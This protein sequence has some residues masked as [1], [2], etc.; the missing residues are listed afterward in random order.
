MSGGDVEDDAPEPRDS[1]PTGGRLRLF[2]DRWEEAGASPWT[3]S[4]VR[5]GLRL[6]LLHPETFRPRRPFDSASV[7]GH[8]DAALVRGL[9]PDM[10]QAR[11]IERC[12]PPRP[13][14]FANYDLI[15]PRLK[16]DGSARP[17][18]NAKKV[19]EHLRPPH[20]RMESVSTALQ[21]LNRGDACV[22]IDVQAAFPHIH[23]P[24]STRQ[25]L[26]FVFDGDHYRFR[27]M[28]FGLSLAPLIFT[29]VISFV[30]KRLRRRGIAL[31]HYCDD[32]LVTAPSPEAVTR[33]ANLV[34]K[35]LRHFGFTINDEKS[36]LTPTTDIVFL[37]VRINTTD[38]TLAVPPARVRDLRRS[39]RRLLDAA[40]QPRPVTG[41]MVAS[42]LGKLAA[43]ARAM[44]RA[45]DSFWNL[46]AWRKRTVRL[47]GWDRGAF[48]GKAETRELR[49]FLTF[50][51]DWNGRSVLSLSPDFAVRF[52]CRKPPEMNIQTDAS[53]W[54]WGALLVGTDLVARGPWSEALRRQSHN[55]KELRAAILAAKGFIRHRLRE[56]RLSGGLPTATTPWVVHLQ[57]DNTTT[58]SYLNNTSTRVRHL[59]ADATA[60]RKWLETRNVILRATHLPG[61]LNGPADDLSRVVHDPH[62]WKLARE[63]FFQILSRFGAPTVDA[64][65]GTGNQQLERFW[66]RYPDPEAAATDAMAQSWR[67][68]DEPLLYINPP[69]PLMHAVINKVLRDR[70]EAVIVAPDWAASWLPRLMG[71]ATGKPLRLVAPL[72]GRLVTP[73]YTTPAFWTNPS[74]PLLA[75]RV[76]GARLWPATPRPQRA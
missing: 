62:D 17:C 64:F 60:F 18:F 71:I 48:L 52:A 43:A 73:G 44:P 61:V 40:V 28:N 2:A 19:N 69:L 22:K 33:D 42:F 13:S 59:H 30:I 34:L 35:E 15:F 26:R 5:D 21:Q 54:A 20:F 67:P 46:D 31:T 68:T 7:L 56:A 41:R 1:A 66:S 32:I 51:E 49:E 9:L 11:L 55:T 50:A 8:Q 37:G 76:S 10:L 3:L 65:A 27:A 53:P 36:E 25:L 4:I 38:M 75:W 24:V 70:A 74:W 57:T 6:R 29:K 47:S 39:A 16:S 23:L 63:S 58:V 12:P 14:E 45:R 72:T